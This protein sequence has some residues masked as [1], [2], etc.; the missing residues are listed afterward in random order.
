MRKGVTITANLPKNRTTTVLPTL[1]DENPNEPLSQNVLRRS[2]SRWI[3]IMLAG[4]V[5]PGG[6]WFVARGIYSVAP[7]PVAALGETFVAAPGLVESTN[8]LRDLS[9][10]VPGRI[11]TVLM[12]EG[13]PVTKG[14]LLA[15]LEDSEAKAREAA[16]QADLGIAEANLKVLSGNLD[17]EQ[18]RAEREVDKWKAEIERLK[19]GPR[20]EE[21]ERARA[22]SSAAEIEWQ[23]R[24]EDAKRYASHPTVSS[25]QEREMTQGL[26]EITHAHF[27]AATAKVRE[28]EAGTRK[29][30][31]A[32]ADAQLQSAEAEAIRVVGTRE[33]RLN[34]AKQQV[35][36][37]RARLDLAQAE[38]RKTRLVSP[39]DGVVVWRFR[40][41]GESVGVLPPERILAVA[42]VKTLRVRADVDEADFAN[43]VPGQRVRVTAEA[44]GD[45]TFAGRVERVSNAAGEKRF[46]TGEARERRDVKIV[47]TTVLFDETP[48]LKLGL[49]VTV[50]FEVEA[51]R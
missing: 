35:E 45:R 21:I 16:A 41:P 42:D 37:A 23:R 8:G 5:I 12:E 7:A 14:Q 22:E 19:A 30:D 33:A 3:T 27:K 47:E 24:V 46:S 48:P 36:Q 39:L 1:V 15:E 26:A 40:H 38:R 17:A 50:L 51:R 18:I 29:E 49:R 6:S 10:E 11:K 4:L 43:I 9:F 2:R 31:L 44:Y 25:Q 13:A 20:P 32:Q 34:A 28:L